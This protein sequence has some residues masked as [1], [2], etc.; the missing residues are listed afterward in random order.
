MPSESDPDAPLLA[1]AY[2][3]ESMMAALYPHLMDLDF[4]QEET[5]GEIS[6]RLAEIMV[7]AKNIYTRALPAFIDSHAQGSES[8]LES[9][10][11]MRMSL[12]FLR[13]V[14]EGYEECLLNSINVSEESEV[15]DEGEWTEE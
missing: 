1:D 9:L 2:E 6:F 3:V 14:I 11:E 7:A 8:S 12:A 13:D 15:D 4:F 5:L 10:M